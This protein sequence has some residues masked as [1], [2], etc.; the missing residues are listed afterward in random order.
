MLSVTNLKIDPRHLD[1]SDKGELAAVKQ[2]CAHRLHLKTSDIV[3]LK[4]VRRSID[5]RN[6]QRIHLLFSANVRL[7]GGEAAEMRVLK[8]LKG[9][10]DEKNVRQASSKPEAHFPLR[11]PNP[12]EDRVVVVGA[13]CAGIFCA[14]ALAH[15]GLEP[16]LIERGDTADRRTQ[17]VKN[18]D[19]TGSLDPESNIQFGMG[20]AGTFS[21]GKLAPEQK[22]RGISWYWKHLPHMARVKIF[23]GMHIR[24]LVAMFF[25]MLSTASAKRL[26]LKAAP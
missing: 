18:F 4:F 7:S 13:G 2:A 9:T 16:L 1:G 12:L 20:G 6:R 10:R 11:R 22:V 21:D 15:A 8:R 14:L 24:T 26:K 5:A 17:A 19:A 25:L 3:T 23:S